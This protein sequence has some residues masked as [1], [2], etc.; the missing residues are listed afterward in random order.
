MNEAEVEEA[1][2]TWLSELGWSVGEGAGLCRADGAG[3]RQDHSAVVLAGRL[4]A[5]LARLN[6]GLPGCS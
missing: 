4:R 1:A 6:P 3:E 2:L 5:A